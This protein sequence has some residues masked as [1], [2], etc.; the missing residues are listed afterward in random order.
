MLYT[1]SHLLLAVDGQGQV[2]GHDVL[3]LDGADTSLLKLL[4]EDAQLLVA[5]EVGT[6]AQTTRPGKDGSNGV[7]RGRVTLRTVRKPCG[8]LHDMTVYHTF[9]CSR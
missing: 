8:Y 4:G 1:A 2:L 9:W 6:V 3:V 5:V 7:G